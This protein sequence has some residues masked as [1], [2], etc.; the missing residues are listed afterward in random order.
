MPQLKGHFGGLAIQRKQVVRESWRGRARWQGFRVLGF[1]AFCL[2]LVL[3]LRRGDEA[4]QAPVVLDELNGV[5]GEA[6]GLRG[7]VQHG[8]GARFVGRGLM[9]WGVLDF[10][11]TKLAL[12][13][14][15]GAAVGLVRRNWDLTPVAQHFDTGRA[16]EPRRQ[17]P[18][19]V[20]RS[21]GTLRRG[22]EPGLGQALVALRGAQ[23]RWLSAPRRAARA[24]RRHRV[25]A[26]AP[27]HRTAGG[28]PGGQKADTHREAAVTDLRLGPAGT[29]RNRT[30]S[31]PCPDGEAPGAAPGSPAALS[32]RLPGP[33]SG[34]APRPA[35]A[36]P[37]P[38]PC[39]AP[40]PAARPEVA[41]G[42]SPEA[43]PRHSRSSAPLRSA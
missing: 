6:A 33:G 38:A 25:S 31:A 18:S 39:S 4:A 22:A 16:P 27:H 35:A 32:P 17:L 12:K 1:D 37:A 40:R 36:A 10:H 5:D 11:S 15:K 20:V 14:V 26:L 30:H 21:E 29:S 19:A 9:Q 43:G 7:D 2:L 41:S 23:S 3:G 8:G 28:S 13:Q 34:P 24:P 42:P